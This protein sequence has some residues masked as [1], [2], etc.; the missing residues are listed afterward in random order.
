M[1][2]RYRLNAVGASVK[3]DDHHKPA[4][5]AIHKVRTN[6]I[7]SLLNECRQHMKLH[8]CTALTMKFRNSYMRLCYWSFNESKFDF[9]HFCCAF[10]SPNLMLRA[11][12]T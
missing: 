3:V 5:S 1:D 9:M 2:N 4:Y 11:S 10:R 6:L 8:V 7:Q 12:K